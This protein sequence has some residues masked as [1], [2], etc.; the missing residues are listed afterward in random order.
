MR[1]LRVRVTV[2]ASLA[3]LVLMAAAGAA[4]VAYQ[5][6]Q[7]FATVDAALDETVTE[8]ERTLDVT[9]GRRFQPARNRLPPLQD[10]VFVVAASPRTLQLLDAD[11]SVV[12]A[13]GDFTGLGPVVDA[14]GILA[15]EGAAIDDTVDTGEV[16]YRV[17]FAVVDPDNPKLLVAGTSLLDVDESLRSQ[18]RGLVVGVPALSAIIG[19]LIWVVL[20]RALTPVEAI[21]REAAE[22]GSEDLSRRVPVPEA[23]IELERLAQTLNGMLAR[24]DHSAEQQRRFVADA[25][26]ELR[27]PL[28]GLRSQLEVNLAHPETA[29]VVDSEEAM[30]AETIRMQTLVE[31]LLV[32]ARTARPDAKVPS[33]RV[34]LDDIVLAEAVRIHSRG[35]AVD[36]AGVSGAQ[37]AGDRGQL[38]RVVRNLADNAARHARSKVGFSLRE[39]DRFIE[40]VVVDDGPGVPATEAEAIFDRF[41]RLSEARDR[42][43][44]GSGLGLAICREIVERHGGSVA[45]DSGHTHGARF[46]VRLPL[47][48]VTLAR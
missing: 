25:S 7:L 42:D 34:D 24:L 4:L 29:D 21:R 32:L 10:V 9:F 27:S 36:T 30:L 41:T 47:P 5:R 14:A 6:N 48:G 33:T 31:D 19:G 46:V 3:T 18:R 2:L 22:I 12:A 35:V 26:H 37:V 43:S 15:D 17:A 28:A 44:G 20:G 23:S 13:S 16:R 38:E 8:V 40:L 39:S 45:L 1:S 11:G